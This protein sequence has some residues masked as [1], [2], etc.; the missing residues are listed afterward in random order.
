MNRYSCTARA[1]GERL[2]GCLK[3]AFPLMPGPVMYRALRARDIRVNGQ[4]AARNLFLT[5]GDRVEIVTA[6]KKPEIPILYEDTRLLVCI[7]PYG[8]SSED[9]GSGAPSLLK[10]L[11][12][13]AAGRYTPKLCHRLDNQT[14]GL[15]LVAKDGVTQELLLRAFRERLVAR[16]YRCLV[17]GRPEPPRALLKAWLTKDAVRA[18]VT[19]HGSRVPGSREILTGYQ[20]IQAGQVSRLSVTLHTGRTHQ[21]RAHLA[22]I[23]HPVLGDDKYGDHAANR[24]Q[25]VSRLMLCAT[26]IGLGG[27]CGL[28]PLDGMRFSVQEPF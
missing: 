6:W 1:D 15:L 2:L 22:Y 18:R 26:A 7:K 8:Y 13:L 20:V 21:I 4:R 14:T 24:S 10:D 16:E 25:R 3:A 23:G 12:E 5:S 27:G 9:D 28:G 11:A 19:V 17:V